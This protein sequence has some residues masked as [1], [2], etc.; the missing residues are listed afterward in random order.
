M[1]DAYQYFSTVSEY[2][3]LWP[4]GIGSRYGTE[5][6]VSSIPAWQCRI[7]IPCSLSLRLFGSLGGSLGTYGLTQ[8]LCSGSVVVTAY[9][10]ESGRPG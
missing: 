1:S 2:P 9:D 6:V 3:S 4:S 7:Y 8:N 10:S 5:Q